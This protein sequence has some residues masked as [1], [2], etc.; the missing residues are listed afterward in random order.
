MYKENGDNLIIRKASE[1]DLPQIMDIYEAARAYMAENGNPTQWTDGYPSEARIR[2][3]LNAGALY[4]CVDKSG[5][6]ED[7]CE[8]QDYYSGKG[9]DILAVFALFIGVEDP[10]YGYIEDGGW[11]NDRPYGVIHRIA[12]SDKAHG[13]G[14]G[15]YCLNKCFE[16]TDNLRIDTHKDNIPMQKVIKR[17][18][19]SYCGIVYMED[20]SP[21]FAYMKTK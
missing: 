3:D 2:D 7:K 5:N 13:R 14:V 1:S 20:G 9:R 10:N 17:A 16:L 15:L 11:L 12:V 21:R 19:F 4:V 6:D 18:G 8:D